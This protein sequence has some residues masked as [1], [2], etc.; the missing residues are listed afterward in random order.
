MTQPLKDL[1]DSVIE[2]GVRALDANMIDDEG[3]I[4]VETFLAM[5]K[6]LVKHDRELRTPTFEGP[7]IKGK[8][9]QWHGGV[10]ISDEQNP[11]PAPPMPQWFVDAYNSLR[12]EG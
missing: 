8:E 7:V 10:E 11:A 1:P 9:R 2:A 12:R 4:A 3:E 5:A 6:A